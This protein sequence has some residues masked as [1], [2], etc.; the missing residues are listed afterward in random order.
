MRVTRL[1]VAGLLAS[2]VSCDSLDVTNPNNPSRVTVE[3][4]AQD[5][6]ALISNGLLQWFNR[7]GGTSPAVAL[8]VMADEFTTGFADFGGQDLSSEPRLAINIQSPNNG[9]PHHVTFPDY[10]SHIAA[11]NTA[12]R[13]ADRGLVL[14]NSAGQDVTTAAVAFAKFMQGLNHGYV[15]LMFDK[16]YVY[17]ETVDPDTLRFSDGA[18]GV[19]DL[20]RPYREVMDTA[21]AELNAALTLA[22]STA[23][24][25]PASPSN[26]WFLGVLRDSDDMARIIHS[27]MAR[28]M[29]YVAR[30][31]QERQDVDWEAVIDH[32]D[33]GITSDFVVMGEVDR[34]FSLF[35]QRGAR[36]RTTI[37]GDFMRVD[38]RLI[39]PGDVTQSFISWYTL[40]WSERNPFRMVGT[41]DKRIQGATTRPDTCIPLT[42][43]DADCGLYMG[44]HNSTLFSAARGT[45][46]RSFYFFH[47]YGSGISWQSGPLVLVNV[48]EMDLLKAEGLIRL[49]R[50][51][52]A[53]P[54]INKYRV[55]NGDLP[56]VDVDGVPATAPDCVPRKLDGSCGSL[57]DALRY[58]KRVETLGLEGGP[59]YYDGRAW[60]F[61]VENTPVHFPIPLRDLELLSINPYTFG[62]V[63]GADGAPA[64]DPE[65]CPVA[66]LRCP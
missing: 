28:L 16:G 48:A 37:P 51:D 21:L 27:Y 61:L 43:P 20:I 50:A 53:V 36:L 14:R 47:R 45:G 32:I 15:A 54:L 4:N 42:I 60:N 11:L 49:G 44:F 39:G 2:T 33:Q 25:Y 22:K 56:P 66:L 57:W 23:F 19:Q 26:A 59:A 10:Y 58:E 31:P 40:P 52:E 7:S 65:R 24:S 30:T 1:L 9:P 18:T 41:P 62:G 34:V 35:K 17:S 8:S 55:A 46:Q 13:A 63:G 12:L 5:A 38:Y 64:P 3:Q 6:L 29:V